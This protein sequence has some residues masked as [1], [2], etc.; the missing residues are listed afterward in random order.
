MALTKYEKLARG[1]KALLHHHDTHAQKTAEWLN[2]IQFHFSEPYPIVGR[3]LMSERTLAAM[4]RT[5]ICGIQTLSSDAQFRSLCKSLP[6]ICSVV[7]PPIYLSSRV[8]IDLSNPSENGKWIVPW[9]VRTILPSSTLQQLNESK[10]EALLYCASENE[11]SEW[12]KWFEQEDLSNT[13]TNHLFAISH[14]YEEEAKAAQEKEIYEKN[15]REPAFPHFVSTVTRYCKENVCPKV[16][17]TLLRNEFSPTKGSSVAKSYELVISSCTRG[18]RKY[19]ADFLCAWKERLQELIFK[20]LNWNAEQRQAA[21]AEFFPRRQ[22]VTQ[23]MKGARWQTGLII[24]RQTY[25]SFIQYFINRFLQDPR[26]Y[27]VDGEIALLLWIMIYCGRKPHINCPITRLLN[28]TTAHVK[29]RIISFEGEKLE[30]S[31][32]L[33]ELLADFIGQPPQE[34]PQKLF[35]NLTLDKLED[36]FRRASAMILP[37]ESQP[38]LP[39]AFLVF[40][41]TQKHLRMRAQLRLAQL[42]QGF[43]IYCNTVSSEEIKRQILE[44]QAKTSPDLP[45]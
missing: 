37:H 34:R 29:N 3:P 38:A 11:M 44:K 19:F 42:K 36:H 1:L 10:L 9:V 31:R 7:T 41:H 26:R 8:R 32:G 25:A 22:L 35:P 23:E 33:A 4:M 28:L 20:D 30:I 2:V 14:Y 27:P 40:P 15:L 13:L 24:D 12:I 6:H 18:N 45:L 43:P 5:H 39:Q 16:A 17:K 21:L